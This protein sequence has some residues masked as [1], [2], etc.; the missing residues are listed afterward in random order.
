MLYSNENKIERKRR[1]RFIIQQTPAPAHTDSQCPANSEKERVRLIN[2]LIDR[3]DWPKESRCREA[4]HLHWNMEISKIDRF[5][6]ERNSDAR[7]KKRRLHVSVTIIIVR[8]LRI[9]QRRGLQNG[10]RER[11]LFEQNLYDSLKAKKTPEPHVPDRGRRKQIHS[12]CI[13]LR[14]F[15]WQYT[16]SEYIKTAMGS[17]V[18]PC[19]PAEQKG[20][21]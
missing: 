16:Y 9:F 8:S 4:S 6:P 20:S 19:G 11:N 13:S 3:N 10:L 21:R 12:A 18:L 5:L 15:W 14:L 7:R 1:K 2:R 17:R